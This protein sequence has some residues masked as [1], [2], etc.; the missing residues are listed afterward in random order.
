MKNSI[1]SVLS[2]IMEAGRL[3]GINKITGHISSIR[4][5]CNEKNGVARNMLLRED[6]EKQ[7]NWFSNF[8]PKANRLAGTSVLK[9]NY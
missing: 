6:N 7:L 8:I 4:T 2:I 5:L 9:R 3:D 1:T